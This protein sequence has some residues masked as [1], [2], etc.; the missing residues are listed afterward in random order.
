VREL[1]TLLEA[2]PEPGTKAWL[3]G[4]RKWWGQWVKA[5]ATVAQI[6]DPKDRGQVLAWFAEGQARIAALKDALVRAA[7]IAVP[8]DVAKAALT[9]MERRPY[10]AGAYAVL[11][12]PARVAGHALSKA[13]EQGVLPH[14]DVAHKALQNMMGRE[15]QWFDVEYPDSEAKRAFNDR[16]GNRSQTGATD[17]GELTS[18]QL[19]MRNEGNAVK[20]VDIEVQAAL[21]AYLKL[22]QVS[23][24]TAAVV[25]EA[26][27][28]EYS[29]GR[30]KVVTDPGAQ[31]D[32]SAL[33][34]SDD[35][36]GAPVG[37]RS[38]N[39]GV[40]RAVHAGLQAA[41]RALVQR[42][43]GGV[44]YG[45][46][47]VRPVARAL[48]LKKAKSGVNFKVAGHY[49]TSEEIVLNPKGWWT[50]DVVAEIAVH[51]LGH[52]YW[53]K[54]MKAGARARFAAWFDP[55]SKADQER[56]GPQAG[57]VPAPTAYGAE[58][59]VEEFAETFAAYVL[60]DYNGVVLTGPQR[61]RFE[62]LALGRAAQSEGVDGGLG[63]LLREFA[64]RAGGAVV[65]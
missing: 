16:M 13:P 8:Q 47:F 29:L 19:E 37:E 28:L 22:L 38:V 32:L 65:R 44:W 61:A 34:R 63:A 55:R 39:I 64:D 17:E 7:G 24:N 14:L 1:L 15:Q 4:V 42:G 52:R 33:A 49:N 43:M 2:A 25:A 45:E 35:I 46:I 58:S 5:A 12:M 26:P 50:P 10:K 3:A 20:A 57:Y 56:E 60:G 59:A 48:T 36:A 9:A 27:P 18:W 62:A 51:E 53:Y 6:R 40:M 11:K 23:P 30:M 54:V 41:Q 31:V 21:R